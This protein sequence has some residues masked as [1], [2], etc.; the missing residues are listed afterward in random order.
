[1]QCDAQTRASPF[2]MSEVEHLCAAQIVAI[3]DD[4]EA[5]RF[6]TGSLIRSLGRNTR[7]YASAEEFLESG[8]I[9]ETS[10]L[11]SDVIMPGMSGVELLSQILALNFTTPTILITSFPTARLN[12]K[13]LELGA[14]VVLGK[15]VDPDAI[16]HWI[17]VALDKS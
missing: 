9:A 4:D 12:A 11:I 16:E 13:A 3:V 5:F 15:P 7:L 17:S 2:L 6:A 8:Q 14:L 1:M 10:C